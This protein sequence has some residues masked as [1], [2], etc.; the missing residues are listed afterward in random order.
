[1]RKLSS[2]AAA[3]GVPAGPMLSAFDQLSDPHFHEC[4]LLVPVDQQQ[5]GPLVFEGPSFAATSMAPPR[6]EQ[7]PLL[8]EHTRE[9]ARELLGL[10]DAEIDR[11][12]AAG[13]LEV[14]RTG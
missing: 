4:G 8:G 3:V 13:V 10:A 2:P 11:L 14:P 5:A 6:I 7:A 9:I 1:M 12:I